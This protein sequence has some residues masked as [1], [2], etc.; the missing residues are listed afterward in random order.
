MPSEEMADG[1]LKLAESRLIFMKLPALMDDFTSKEPQKII[2]YGKDGFYDLILDKNCN[3][4]SFK[5]F[6][7]RVFND[8]VILVGWNLKRIFSYFKFK[9]A[10]ELKF[11]C[12]TIDLMVV[13]RFL[14]INLDAPAT[15]GE[16]VERFKTIVADKSWNRVYRYVYQP[17]MED[18]IP[19]LECSGIIDSRMGYGQNVLFSSYDIE[20]HKHCR[21]SSRRINKERFYVP[22]TIPEDE[23]KFYKP[24]GMDKVFFYADYKNME[25]CVIAWLTKD[26]KLNDLIDGGNLYDEVSSEILIK[27]GIDL[28][29]RQAKHGLI[30]VMYGCGP[31]ALSSFLKIDRNDASIVVKTIREMFP[32]AFEWFSSHKSEKIEDFFGRT[33]IFNDG[34]LF[35]SFLI[36]CPSAIVCQHKLVAVSK[37]LPETCNLVMNIHDG[38]LFSTDVKNLDQSKEI[39]KKI[40]EKNEVLYDGLKLKISINDGF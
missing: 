39:I 10:S 40:M 6:L 19:S 25:L 11:K 38:Y 28:V 20:S 34:Y 32:V 23:K 15:Y 35:R 7:E 9:L 37:N 29:K 16:F 30:A 2:F 17:L 14:N 21:L 31:E 18:V 12:K 24:R 4:M 8:G 26:Q 36:Q 27:T 1:F 5:F 22:H 13:E 3:L 33:R